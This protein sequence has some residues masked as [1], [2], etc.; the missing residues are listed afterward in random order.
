MF[1]QFTAD[2]NKR[3]QAQSP[4]EEL[5]VF[6]PREGFRIGVFP[7]ASVNPD[8]EASDDKDKTAK[9]P[10][11]PFQVAGQLTSLRKGWFKVAT[12]QAVVSGELAED[13]HVSFDIADCRHAKPG[14]TIEVNAWY[15]KSQKG[16]GLAYATKLKI[17]ALQ[18]LTGGGAARRGRET[19]KT[20]EKEP[21][22]AAP[23]APD[24]PPVPPP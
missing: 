16:M 22:D 18:P 17:A 5:T 11:A 10:A 4:V 14:D 23:E 1:V 24:A 12:G 13:V 9:V 3:G 8:P 20:P 19:T 7:A 6:T 2:F 21:P 15:Y